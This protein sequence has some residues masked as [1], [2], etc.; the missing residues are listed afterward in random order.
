MSNVPPELNV[1]SPNVAKDV[2]H[3]AADAEGAVVA[4][5]RRFA[6]HFFAAI[7]GHPH[8]VFA[9]LAAAAV[10][11]IAFAVLRG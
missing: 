7:A 6:A 3:A 11:G 1:G 5:R 9:L 8:A 4:A 10:I 2:Q